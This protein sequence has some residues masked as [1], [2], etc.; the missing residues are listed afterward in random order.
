MPYHIRISNRT[1]RSHEEI[2]LDMT[3]EQVKERFI[4]PYKNGRAIMISG[5]TIPF[6]AIERINIT[7]TEQSSDQLLPIIRAERLT[8]DLPTEYSDEWVVADRGVD[9]TDEF[10]TKPPEIAKNLKSETQETKI[11]NPRGVFVVHGRNILARD[12]I[13]AFLRSIGLSPLEWTAIIKASGKASPYTGHIIDSGLSFA[14]AVVV[15]MTPDD[16]ARLREPFRMAED[17]AYESELTPQPRPNVIFEAGIAVGRFTR[18]RTIFVRLGRLRPFS[19]IEGLQV[20]KLTNA[21][22]CRQDLAQ[23]LQAAGCPVDLSGTDWHSA[24]GDFDTLCDPKEREPKH[25]GLMNRA[26]NKLLDG[27][28]GYDK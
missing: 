9:V 7:Y 4:T 27:L 17:Q 14:R 10:I 6:D 20:V 16:E 1:D 21:T 18:D 13:F 28:E 11:R 25:K 3:R 23:R 12:A 26:R 24:G 15:L 19:D 8:S 22:Q 2:K 5:K